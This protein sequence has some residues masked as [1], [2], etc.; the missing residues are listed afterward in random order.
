[1]IRKFVGFRR[2]TYRECWVAN[3]LII[4]QAV[5]CI[6]FTCRVTSNKCR[7][8]KLLVSPRFRDDKASCSS[9]RLNGFRD[10]SDKECEKWEERNSHVAWHC[11]RLIMSVCSLLAQGLN[12]PTPRSSP[13][14]VE[15][16]YYSTYRRVTAKVGQG[17]PSRV[18]SD[19]RLNLKLCLP[20]AIGGEMVQTD[21]FKLELLESGERKGRRQI[22]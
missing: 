19:A 9:Q 3:F 18:F 4:S 22:R 8:I 1:M 12:S 21:R 7:A 20:V 17:A 6:Q 5:A 15:H 11:S 10:S 16:K 13:R 14:T 2:R